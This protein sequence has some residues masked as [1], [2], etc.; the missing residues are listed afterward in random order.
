L[1]S[2]QK[3]SA[4]QGKILISQLVIAAAGR[5]EIM[6]GAGVT[7][8]NAVELL[9]TGIDALHLTA[10]ATRPSPMQYSNPELTMASVV[11]ANDFEIVYSD[12][13]KIRDVVGRC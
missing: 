4:V 6:A 13:D 11:N 5:I 3:P 7:A 1:T 9:K 2:G 12:T 8:D 10:K